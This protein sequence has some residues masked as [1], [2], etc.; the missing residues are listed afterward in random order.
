MKRRDFLKGVLGVSA[1]VVV[2]GVVSGVVTETVSVPVTASMS[3]SKTVSG[4]AKD[5]WPGVNAWYSGEHAGLE[6]EF[7]QIFK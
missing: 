2:P 3:A 6:P 7:T 1:A 5:L 4:F